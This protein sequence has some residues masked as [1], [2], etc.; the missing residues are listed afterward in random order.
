MRRVRTTD[1]AKYYGQPIGT[2]ITT[3]MIEAARAKNNGKTPPRGATSQSRVAHNEP[4]PRTPPGYR[5]APPVEKTS[6]T[7]VKAP[8]KPPKPPKV[9]PGGSLKGP[10]KFKL[11]SKTYPMPAGTKVYSRESDASIAYVVPPD[12]SLHIY[13]EQGELQVS[14]ELEAKVKG[15]LATDTSLKPIRSEA[16]VKEREKNLAGGDERSPKDQKRIDKEKAKN[17]SEYADGKKKGLLERRRIEKEKAKNLAAGDKPS[18]ADAAERERNLKAYNGDEKAAAAKA[19]AD[20]IEADRQSKKDARAEFE[21]A[22]AEANAPAEDDVSR[23]EK[24]GAEKPKRNPKSLGEDSPP[25]DEGEVA[26]MSKSPYTSKHLNPDGTFT[27]ERIALHDRIIEDFLDGLEESENPTQYM[28]G[29]GPASGKGSMTLGANKALTNY[30]TSR[31]VNTRTGKFEAM[32]GKPEALLIDPD[33]VKVQFPE[34]QEAIDRMHSDTFTDEDQSWA[35]AIHE[36]SSQVAKRL[37]KAAL[38]RGYNV[39]YDGTGNG[40]AKSVKKKVDAAR[41]A[42]YRVEANYLYLDPEEGVRRAEAR[43][44]QS[45]RTVPHEALTS[46]YAAL[47]AIFD[48]IKEGVF[49]KVNLFDNNV[50]RGQPAKLIGRGEGGKFEILDQKAYND[51]IGSDAAANKLAAAYEAEREKRS[52]ELRTTKSSRGEDTSPKA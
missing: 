7:P 4:A 18:K 45:K 19:S 27:K 17:E 10:E 30:P 51:Y 33:A 6:A 31:E 40:S 24:Q 5:P 39:I 16:D 36:E 11:G 34:V 15:L 47:P 20:K 13:T 22:R 3:D 1:G 26:A 35:G 32:E 46:T 48:E 41:A 14:P 52:E 42:G 37:H 43:A 9:K 50:E 2:P 23:F 25:A 38:D 8:A 21:K 44:Q 49:D 28:N 12:G 29:G